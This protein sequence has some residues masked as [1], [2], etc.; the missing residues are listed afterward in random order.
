M[1]N[2]NLNENDFLIFL[3]W[4][5]SNFPFL[6]TKLFHYLHKKYV[7]ESNQLLQ[8]HDRLPPRMIREE[9]VNLLAFRQ[10]LVECL[11][12]FIFQDLPGVAVIHLNVDFLHEAFEFL[13][14]HLVIF[15]FI[16]FPQASMDPAVEMIIKESTWEGD[17]K[18]PVICFHFRASNEVQVFLLIFEDD[19]EA[20]NFR[21]ILSVANRTGFH[22]LWNKR[23][24]SCLPQERNRIFLELVKSLSSPGSGLDFQKMTS[25]QQELEPVNSIDILLSRL[26]DYNSHYPHPLTFGPYVIGSFIWEPPAII[27][28]TIWTLPEV[29]TNTAAHSGLFL[30]NNNHSHNDF[31]SQMM[32]PKS[33]DHL[34]GRKIIFTRLK[35]DLK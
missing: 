17:A 6:T 34:E 1:V 10:Y 23:S 8:R 15:V 4:E 2:N 14:A 24:V 13:K 9:S 18:Y 7:K 12:L 33:K 27:T 32:S 26:L 22:F 28:T 5:N 29:Q 20:T 35:S 3:S 11:N 21:D 30:T 16:C 19:G 31:F 25:S